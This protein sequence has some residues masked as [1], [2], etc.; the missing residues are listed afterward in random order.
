[1]TGEGSGKRWVPK[2][3]VRFTRREH[4]GFLLRV[5]EGERG[6]GQSTKVSRL[7]VA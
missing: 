2:N 1:M 6:K 5:T 7:Q 3:A 4:G